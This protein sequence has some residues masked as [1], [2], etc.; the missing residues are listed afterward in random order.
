MQH[1]QSPMHQAQMRQKPSR[2]VTADQSYWNSIMPFIGENMPPRIPAPSHRH[3]AP[4]GPWPFLDLNDPIN[5]EQLDDHRPA[6]PTQLCEHINPANCRRCWS[7]Y[8]QSH[9]PNWTRDQ[10]KRSRISR[11]IEKKKDETCTI[12]YVDVDENGEFAMS[13]S[14]QVSSRSKDS[15]WEFMMKPRPKGTRLRAMFLENLT[16][17][18]LQMLGTKYY[19]EPFYFSSS[20]GW[21]PSRYQE[22]VI[23][24]HS[25]HI[26]ISLTFIRTMPNPTPVS[27][28]SSLTASSMSHLPVLPNTDQVIDAQAPLFIRSSDRILLPDLLALHMVRSHNSSTI[29][30]YHPGHEHRSTPAASLHSRLNAV[31]HSVYWSNMFAEYDDPTL[32]FLSLLWYALYAW[33]EVLEVL[34][35]HIC[36]VESRVINLN[37]IDLTQELHIIQAHLLHYGSLLEDFRK[38]V[39]FVLKTPFPGLDNPRYTPQLRERSKGHMEKE[40]NNLLSEIERLNMARSMQIKRLKNVMNLAFSSVN[41]E[42]SRRTQQLTRASMNDSAAMK[43]IAY[44]TMFFLPASLVATIFGMNVGEIN[45]GTYGT[46]PHYLAIAVPLTI[47]TC[48]AIGTVQFERDPSQRAETEP[49]LMWRVLGRIGWPIMMLRETCLRENGQR[50]N[51]GSQ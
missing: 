9:F 34:Y 49:S 29:I 12:H 43:Q 42:D 40:C 44:L 25:D 32:V 46:I 7:D 33:D 10:Q 19:I 24:N 20:I 17:P 41:I 13:N 22:Q 23:S 39:I 21:I 14:V 35:A 6:L 8:P 36:W 18:V 28:T 3:A 30:S 4:S 11:I 37:D 47:I 38:S 2:S 5:S 15:H 1:T 31:G 51:P 27:S 16:G 45:P 48:W 50:N 26:T